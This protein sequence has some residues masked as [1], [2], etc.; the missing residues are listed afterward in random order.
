MDSYNKLPDAEIKD[1][2]KMSKK[3]LELGITSFR[4]ACEYVHNIEYGYNSDYD[5]E[6]IFLLRTRVTLLLSLL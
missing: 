5:D 2:G 1:K 4:E 3:F 6:M